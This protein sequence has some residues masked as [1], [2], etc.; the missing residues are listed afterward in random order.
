MGLDALCIV[1]GQPVQ[2]QHNGRV[3]APL[4][5]DRS[6]LGR[7]GGSVGFGGMGCLG[8]VLELDVLFSAV[9]GDEIAPFLGYFALNYMT[10]IL[11]QIN[12]CEFGIQDLFTVQLQ[13]L[14]STHIIQLMIVNELFDSRVV[15][16]YKIKILN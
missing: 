3:R 2:R 6:A 5:R 11:N 16:L 14:I 12:K 15:Y 1:M 7:S 4:G 9:L 10:H 8:V 13:H